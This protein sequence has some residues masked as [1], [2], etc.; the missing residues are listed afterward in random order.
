MTRRLLSL[1]LAAAA[2]GC[3]LGP[4]YQRPAVPAPATW[5]E[6][7]AAE[8]QSLANTPWWELF[9]DPQLQELI[10]IALVEN[11]D[12]KIAVER[13]EEARARYGFA[14]ADFWPQVSASGAA[15]RVKIRENGVAGELPTTSDGSDSA[16][17]SVSA[18][19]SWEIDFFGR[20]RRTTRG[21]AGALPR[22]RGGTARGGADAGRGRG[23][24]LLRAARPRPPARDLA[25][26]D[27]VA[28]RVRRA[29]QG[30]LRGRP[31][32]RDRLPP[33]RGRAAS[34]GGRG[35]RSRAPHRAQGERAVGPAR[36]QPGLG[37]PRPRHRRAEAPGG[38][39]RRPAVGAA[40]PPARRPRG[41]AVA[42]RRHGQHRRRQGP[43]LPAHRPHR[44]LRLRQH[45]HRHSLRRTEPSR[46]T[47]SAAC[48]SRSSTPDRTGG[49]SR[50]PSRSSDRRSTP[51]SGR[52]SRPSA[53]P[54]TPS[55][56]TGSWASNAAA[57]AGR[58][59]AERK[60]LELAELRYR[61]GVAAYLEVLDAQ[62]SLFDAELDEA[63]TIG[64]HLTSLVRLYKALGGGWPTE[65]GA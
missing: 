11:K 36:P 40:R 19:V 12:L 34:G 53:R 44:L 1:F 27:R 38:G 10:R 46:G 9:D 20:V 52:S 65:P 5:R 21:A 49:G 25:A 33:G 48:S 35:L 56:P 15:G 22:H 61:G 17:Y 62:R 3:A 54:R 7:P 13:I 63:Q 32:P 37:H 43:A 45:R 18:D 28:A 24:G 47:S 64:S 39:P 58:V 8:A 31:H 14:K 60:V 30:P 26:H 41:R 29:R 42:R 59:Q 51:T 4:N 2:T 57:Q 23:P 6:I 55:S 50:S 16:V